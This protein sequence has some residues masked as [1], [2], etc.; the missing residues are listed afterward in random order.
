MQIM[1][2]L[3][4]QFQFGAEI[5][6]MILGMK[7]HRILLLST[8]WWILVFIGSF[9]LLSFRRTYFIGVVTG[10]CMSGKIWQI[11]E[12]LGILGIDCA[13]WEIL[14]SLGILETLWD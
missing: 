3:W 1:H 2:T 5:L 12:S 7:M 13:V 8:P 4:M 14:E 6:E 10:N 11:W 9:G